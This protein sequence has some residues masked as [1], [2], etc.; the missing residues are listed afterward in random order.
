M[1]LLEN[2]NKKIIDLCRKGSHLYVICETSAM[3]GRIRK[4]L[5]KNKISYRRGLFFWKGIILLTTKDVKHFHKYFDEV[6]Y[7][8]KI[9]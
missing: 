1:I 7:L 4:E 5:V 6:I 3:K 8:R 2:E 9:K